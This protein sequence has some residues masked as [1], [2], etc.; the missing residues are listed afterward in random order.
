M[1]GL[2]RRELRPRTRRFCAFRP[3]RLM[4]F[5]K[6]GCLPQTWHLAPTDAPL[7]SKHACTWRTGGSDGVVF[8]ATASDSSE[9]EGPFG[10]LLPE[11]LERDVRGGRRPGLIWAARPA[12]GCSR[13]DGARDT[14]FAGRST[15]ATT[16]RAL[17]DAFAWTCFESTA[18]PHQAR[19]RPAE[20]GSP[21]KCSDVVEGH[22]DRDVAGSAEMLEIRDPAPLRV[23][24]ALPGL[25]AGEPRARPQRTR[26][27][28]PP[29][30]GSRTPVMNRSS[31]DA[32]NTAALATSHAVPC[33]PIGTSGARA[34]PGRPSPSRASAHAR[35]PP[36]ACR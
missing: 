28:W 27:D 3:S 26:A 18:L 33:R 16:R 36:S 9:S 19:W 15:A 1:F 23:Q 14:V 5:P 8:N 11:S 32:R 12:V 2:K 6:V 10:T 31:S 35:R 29:S 25:R 30:T 20:A 13:P 24:L 17:I 34:P 21:S 7:K 22:V 4:V